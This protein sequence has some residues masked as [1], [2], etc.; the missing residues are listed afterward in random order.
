[1]GDPVFSPDG[2]FMWTGSEWIPSPPNQGVKEN[3][4]SPRCNL[5]EEIVK[6]RKGEKFLEVHLTNLQS[7][8]GE[9]ISR[10]DL[11]NWF[12]VDYI[13]APFPVQE[14]S[15]KWHA[16]LQQISVSRLAEN[17]FKWVWEAKGLVG[18]MQKHNGMEEVMIVEIID[19]EENNYCDLF[20]QCYT[21]RTKSLFLKRD[22]D[23]KRTMPLAHAIFSKIIFWWDWKANSKK[24]D[25]SWILA[26]SG[27]LEP[28][29]IFR[30]GHVPSNYVVAGR[31]GSI[32]SQGKGV[33]KSN[34]IES[35]S[36][37]SIGSSGF[38]HRKILKNRAGTWGP[39]R[40]ENCGHRDDRAM[41]CPVCWGKMVK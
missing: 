3:K 14:L 31:I 13:N 11:Y 16:S 21:L 4:Q 6:P 38:N 18:K 23:A 34:P 2:Q 15:N 24:H 29:G 17:K 33:V 25:L 7:D 35:T 37:S 20:L 12:E 32:G 9:P 28:I 22:Q 19:G 36:Y 40:C 5:K 1:M 26:K 39:A 8:N 41:Q 30:T 10:Q 27:V